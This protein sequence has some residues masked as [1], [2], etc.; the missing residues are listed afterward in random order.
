MSQA[1]CLAEERQDRSSSGSANQ[2]WRSH[3]L[4]KLKVDLSPSKC[5]FVATTRGIALTLC[6]GWQDQGFGTAPTK[7]AR[8]LG[9]DVS[10]GGR[11][12]PIA[13]KR[14]KCAFVRP[15]RIRSFAKKH[16]RASRLLFKGGALPQS[17]YGHQIWGI[18]PTSMKRLRAEAA[19]TTGR[20]WAGMCTTTLLAITKTEAASRIHAEVITEYLVFLRDNPS[21]TKRIER[22]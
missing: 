21:Q 19:W 17:T 10:F 2:P 18:P 22:A 1:G 20:Y 15:R 6:S 16:T 3:S 11:S 12:L 4:E 8:D 14:A 13:R 9:V 7:H 5:G